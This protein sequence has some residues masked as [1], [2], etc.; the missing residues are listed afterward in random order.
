MNDKL[1]I[2]ET[3][4]L[5]TRTLFAQRNQFLRIGVLATLGFF[6]IAILLQS[7]HVAASEPGKEQASRGLYFLAA[8]LDSLLVSVFSVAWHRLTLLG[9]QSL[10]SGIGM[11]LQGRELLYWG[12]FWLLVLFAILGIGLMD[13]IGSLIA[14]AGRLSHTGLGG[15][16]LI[17]SALVVPYACA[18]WSPVFAATSI[19]QEFS[20]VK[21]WRATAGSG[22][23][24]LG[25]YLL[26]GLSAFGMLGVF[27]W[28]G[29]ALGLAERAPYAQLFLRDLLDCAI[30]AIWVTTNALVYRRLSNPGA[31]S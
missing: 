15:I 7:P 27:H 4:T 26:A 12:R 24:L 13:F 18:R 14:S 31:P 8:V 17:G 28:I 2:A 5:A 9:P 25:L 21:A 11:R 22:M 30:L 20:F 29:M 6:V 16:V 10:P 23:R 3:L 1:P 19:D